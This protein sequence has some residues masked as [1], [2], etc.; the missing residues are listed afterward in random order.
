MEHT[1]SKQAFF[2]I[3]D[4]RN[5]SYAKYALIHFQED[6]GERRWGETPSRM[7]P[8]LL[9][10]YGGRPTK[11]ESDHLIQWTKYRSG[12][13]SDIMLF[14]AHTCIPH[15]LAPRS[16]PRICKSP[17]YSLSKSKKI[18]IFPTLSV[19]FQAGTKK[20]TTSAYFFAHPWSEEEKA[21]HP[22]GN[23]GRDFVLFALS[24]LAQSFERGNLRPDCEKLRTNLDVVGGQTN[25]AAKMK[26][27]AHFGKKNFFFCFSP[28]P[29]EASS[30][31]T[32]SLKTDT[33]RFGVGRPSFAS[34]GS[35]RGTLL[36]WVVQW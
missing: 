29:A 5:A 35:F 24:F 3:P 1:R 30:P 34:G 20:F 15:S 19:Y 36:R 14:T 7:E 10:H 4:L 26:I 9:T 23:C 31:S 8:S 28:V 27:D 33:K 12:Q 25:D 16:P 18:I 2:S 32:T 13:K 11:V 6:F 21:L 17:Q 22:T